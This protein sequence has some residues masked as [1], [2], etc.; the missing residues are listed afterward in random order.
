MSTP[1]NNLT[2]RAPEETLR[3]VLA[4]LDSGEEDRPIDFNQVLPQPALDAADVRPWRR[5]NWGT[6][7]SPGAANFE[8]ELEG[9]PPTEGERTLL[10]T[11]DGGIMLPFLTVLAARHPQLEIDWM[12]GD[13]GAGF[14][15]RA[16]FAGGKQTS[17]WISHDSEE[18]VAFLR[19]HW[20]DQLPEWLDY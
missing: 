17:T 3:T 11:T 8:H 16:T 10:F 4:E 7:F 19:E 1:S 6:A 15:G 18:C 5:A 9:R 12:Y 14:V 20:E 13:Y 2:L